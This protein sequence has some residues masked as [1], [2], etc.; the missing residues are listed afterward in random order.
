MAGI[1]KGNCRLQEFTSLLI[2]CLTSWTRALLEK[3][4][5][6]Q[7]VK[8]IPAVNGK[9]WFITSFKRAHHLSLPLARS[10]Q[11]MPPHHMS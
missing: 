6:F 8:K 3:L 2:Y 4:T 1:G 11:S 5:V 9:Q 10:I 7:L